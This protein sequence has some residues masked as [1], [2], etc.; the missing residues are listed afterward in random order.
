MLRKARK[1]LVKYIH[2]K[3]LMEFY[4]VKWFLLF[5][6]TNSFFILSLFNNNDTN[7][8][9]HTGFYT[10]MT[11]LEVL[12]ELITT[13]TQPEYKSVIPNDIMKVSVLFFVHN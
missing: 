1:F 10:N 7:I 11:I 5:C 9:T 4:P 6:S 2:V 8:L 13:M 3:F 12:R